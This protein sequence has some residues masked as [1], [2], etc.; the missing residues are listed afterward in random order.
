MPQGILSS[1]ERQSHSSH[2]PTLY[3]H[4]QYD[5]THYKKKDALTN[6]KPNESHY[7][8]CWDANCSSQCIHKYGGSSKRKGKLPY[9]SLK[10]PWVVSKSAHHRDTYIPIFTETLF[11][12]PKLWNQSR[13]PPIDKCGTYIQKSFKP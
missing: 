8:L 2:F 7:T 12:I 9:E 5:L 13:C 1:M 10:H 6:P 4:R 3:G 11:I